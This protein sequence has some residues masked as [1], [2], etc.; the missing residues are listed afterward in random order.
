MKRLAGL[1][2]IFAIALV[3]ALT[4]VGAQ[5]TSKQLEQLQRDLRAAQNARDAQAARATDLQG[6]IKNL[7][8]QESRLNAQVTELNSR[9][10]KLETE[11]AQTQTQIDNTQRKSDALALEIKA[12]SAKIDYQKIQVSRLIVS[13]D[14][15]RSNR[16]VKLLARAENAFDL[17][18]KTRDLD[19]IQDVNLN[20]ITE[21][22]D[23]VAALNKKNNEYI[24]VIAK[25]NGYQRTL[26]AKKTA[27]TK[28]RAAL[29]TSINGLRQT[30]LGR[31][32]LLLQAVRAQQAASAQ[33][34]NIFSRL[35]AEK[36]RLRELRRRAA[37][38][39]R[40][41]RI[42]E[43]RRRAAEEARI[44]AIRDA[45]ARERQQALEAQRQAQAN[46]EIASVAPIALPSSIGRLLFPIS[47]GRI[48]ADF[49][50]EGDWMVITAPEAGAPV[51]AA[52]NGVVL[53]SRLVAANY[54]WTVIVAHTEDLEVVTTY[55]NLQAPNMFSGQNVRAGQVIGYTGGGTLLPA[56]ELHFQVVRGS[57]PVNPRG[58]F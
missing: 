36:A 17:A 5:T 28:N 29:N 52:A 48:T 20:V 24:A 54:G 55:G 30:Q 7:S 44:A 12:L 41:K 9:L 25:L 11:R 34:L 39:A 6:Q 56:N 38:E 22:R 15:E 8:A 2:A 40:R 50:S 21:L 31:K 42:E 4:P 58:Y 33:A 23:N 49:G 43:A 46:T 14:L 10:T 3:V 51:I 35:E 53:E 19:T 47:G 13:L 18:V 16:Y 45:Q 57:N 32:A 26:E 1:L 37:E 27:I